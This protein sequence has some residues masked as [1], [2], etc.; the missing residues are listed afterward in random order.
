MRMGGR[1]GA[2]FTNFKFY[3]DKV[4]EHSHVHGWVFVPDDIRK[5][6]ERKWNGPYINC[7]PIM[8]RPALVCYSTVSVQDIS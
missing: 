4:L 8:R 1:R 2:V 3:G 7:L 5:S 6:W